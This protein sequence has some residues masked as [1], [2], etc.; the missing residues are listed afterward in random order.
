MSN[1][2]VE[3]AWRSGR[4]SDMSNGRQYPRAITFKLLRLDDRKVILKEKSKALQHTNFF[5]SED[6]IPADIDLRRR[7]KPVM[8]QAKADGKKFKFRGGKL[9]IDGRLFKGPFPDTASEHQQQEQQ[10]QQRQQHSHGRP[11]SSQGL[12]QHPAGPQPA[13]LG[14][15]QQQAPPQGGPPPPAPQGHQQLQAP[16]QGGPPPPATL[17]Y[18]Q[19]Q[20]PPQGGP[21]LPATQVYQLQ[22]APPQG[23]PPPPATQVYQQPHYYNASQQPQPQLSMSPPPHFTTPPPALPGYANGSFVQL[24]QANTPQHNGVPSVGNSG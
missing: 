20:A 19:Q 23:G 6:M 16:P 8:D 9:I 21:P 18:Q 1:V 7:L 3:D 4:K 13:P 22:Q 12:Q 5:I 17:V 24:L 10:G 2:E 14:H 11:H 15:Q